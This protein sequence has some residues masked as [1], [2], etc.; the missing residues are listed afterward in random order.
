MTAPLF[1]ENLVFQTSVK[2][3]EACNQFTVFSI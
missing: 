2:E 1:P 3:L